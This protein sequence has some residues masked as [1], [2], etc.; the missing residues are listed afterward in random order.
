MS[1]TN[2]MRPYNEGSCDAILDTA[3]TVH[4][5]ESERFN[6]CENK[7]NIG[8]A[9]TGVILGAYITYLGA[10]KPPLKDASYLTYTLVFKASIL[11]L[12]TVAII[13]FLKS[14]KKGE[15]E[16][17]DLNNII[18][19]NFARDNATKVKLE[20]AATYNQVIVNNRDKLDA[21]LRYY[22]TGLKFVTWGFLLFV[23]HFL[24]EEII[25]YA[26]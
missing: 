13:Y 2:N 3:K 14:I 4:A 5:E 22:D 17:I 15:Y 8:L 6:Q 19:L 23:I 25:K 20:I 12:L 24:L 26:K 10:Y 1:Q 11:V 18:D 16:Q 21:K 9:F 7:T